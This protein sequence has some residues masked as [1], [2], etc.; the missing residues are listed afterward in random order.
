MKHKQSRI[1][2]SSNTAEI[3]ND[4]G[5]ELEAASVG[6]IGFEILW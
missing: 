6:E 3:L 1:L 2:E 5:S 4:M